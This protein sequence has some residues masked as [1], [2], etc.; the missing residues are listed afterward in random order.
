M[1]HESGKPTDDTVALVAFL[2]GTQEASGTCEN[3]GVRTATRKWAESDMALTHGW[4]EDWCNA[5]V[6]RRQIDV[7]REPAAALPKLEA[8]LAALPSNQGEQT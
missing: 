4:L 1:K 3:C 2:L 8:E 7:A 6:L 5:C